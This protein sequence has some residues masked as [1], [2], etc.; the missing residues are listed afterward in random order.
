MIESKIYKGFQVHI[1]KV[2]REKHNLTIED[3]LIWESKDDEIIIKVKKQ[4]SLSDLANLVIANEEV[5]AV[6]IKKTCWKRWN[7]NY[8]FLLIPLF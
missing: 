3:K 7:V 1:P 6:E 5:D 2:I 8:E 4:R